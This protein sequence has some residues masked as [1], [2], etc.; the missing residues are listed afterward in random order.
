MPYGLTAAG[1]WLVAADTA[2]SRLLA[3]RA[4][5]LASGAAAAALAAQDDF[6]ARGDER[7]MEPARP[8]RGSLSWPYGVASR[9]GT[10]A[11]ADSGNNRVLLW[12]LA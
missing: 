3:W 1:D 8:A 5:E 7:S 6:H 12:R 2:S 10:L 9:D 4:A 11:I